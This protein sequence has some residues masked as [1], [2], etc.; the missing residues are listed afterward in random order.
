MPYLI[1]VF[2]GKLVVRG[3]P[4]PLATTGVLFMCAHRTLMDPLA[5]TVAL[6]RRVTAVIYSISR[7]SEL[8]SPIRTA[9][10]SRVREVDTGHIAAELAWGDLVVC[11]EGTTCREPFLLRFSML[12]AKLTDRIVPV[13]IDYKVGFFHPTTATGW[14]VMDPLFFF[15]NPRS[16]YEVTF[17]SQL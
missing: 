1:P 5:L 6:G 10:L 9:R 11:P 14:K 7:L 17:L 4:P 15:M 12:F 8:L 2:G 13:A 16:A 3:R